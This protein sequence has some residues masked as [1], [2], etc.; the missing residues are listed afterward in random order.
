MRFLD[1]WQAMVREFHKK[2]G[3]PIGDKPQT[4]EMIRAA[5]RCVLIQEEFDELRSAMRSDDL[6]EIADA[7]VDLLYV[8]I[9]AAVEYGIDLGP[10]FNEV[11]RTNMAKTGGGTR[12]DGKI[13]KP[14]CWKGPDIDGLLMKQGWVR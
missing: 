7:L 5:F 13:K 12:S 4:I 10:L 14:D 9:G 11:H 1:D 2:F 8:T 3:Q 6:P